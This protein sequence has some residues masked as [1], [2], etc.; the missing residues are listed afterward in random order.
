[1]CVSAST[2]DNCSSEWTAFESY[3]AMEHKPPVNP[4]LLE[5]ALI[6]RVGAVVAGQHAETVLVGF[7][8]WL[9]VMRK[10]GG[11]HHYKAPTICKYTR[12]ACAWQWNES[13]ATNSA[14]ASSPRLS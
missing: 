5:S 6:Q 1:M 13:A 3:C 14:A 10:N 7:A 11:S 8:G 4:L 9:T 2:A 12:G